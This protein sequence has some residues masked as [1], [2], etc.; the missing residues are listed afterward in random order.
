VVGP[1]VAR[2]HATAGWGRSRAFVGW[3]VGVHD[4]DINS[5]PAFRTV[6][7][8]RNTNDSCEVLWCR[9]GWCQ[10]CGR[11]AANGERV[12]GVVGPIRAVTPGPALSS[13]AWLLVMLA[14][15]LET[16][17]GDCGSTSA[18][19]RAFSGVTYSTRVGTYWPR[20]V[21]TA[22]RPHLPAVLPTLR[23]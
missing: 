22:R 1:H 15:G 11:C 4:A 16:G 19:S 9:T 10:R 14:R 18:P 2:R 5:A 23:Q 7:E 21:R 6:E 20:V 8:P 13:A 17:L 12:R 3:V